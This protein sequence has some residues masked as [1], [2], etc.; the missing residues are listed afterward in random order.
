MSCTCLVEFL[1]A[2]VLWLPV[3]PNSAYR[4]IT[5]AVHFVV[6]LRRLLLNLDKTRSADSR[7]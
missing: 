2:A 5:H 3:L 7:N 1:S 4:P 6:N